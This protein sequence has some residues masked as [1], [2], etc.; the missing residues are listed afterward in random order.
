M[1]EVVVGKMLLPCFRLPE[2]ISENLSYLLDFLFDNQDVVDI[3]T[4]YPAGER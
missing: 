3:L 4:T 2:N 1:L